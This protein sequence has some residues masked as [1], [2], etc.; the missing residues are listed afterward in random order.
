MRW[1]DSQIDHRRLGVS[2]SITG[3]S[4]A[5][6]AARSWIFRACRP[7]L[8]WSLALFGLGA[9]GLAGPEAP[10]MVRDF[11]PGIQAVRITNHAGDIFVETWNSRFIRV[12]A[13]S[14]AGASSGLEEIVLCQAGPDGVADVRTRQDLPAAQAVDLWLYVPAGVRLTARSR[15]GNVVILPEGDPSGT[16]PGDSPRLA[17]EMAGGEG[18]PA[19]S[20]DAPATSPR[21]A[22][23]SGDTAGA[24]P[25]GF[26]LKVDTRLVSL[27]VKVDNEAGASL[28][29]LC[30]EDFRVLDNGAEQSVVYFEPQAA[31]L[32]LL[33]LLDL[34]GSTKDKTNLIKRA[35]ARFVEMLN[36]ADR[37]AVAAFTSRYMQVSGFTENR[38][39]LRQR[40]DKIKNRGG[41][42]AFYEAMWYAQDE[43]ADTPGRRNIIV[44]MSDGVDNVLQFPD[45]YHSKWSFEE[46]LGRVSGADI[47]VFPVY[48]DTEYEQVVEE[49]NTSSITYRTARKQIASLAE[50]S[51]GTMFTVRRFEDLEGVYRLVASELRNLYTLSYYAPAKSGGGREWHEVKVEIKQ[52]GA[53]ARTRPGY[54]LH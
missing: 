53:R 23:A 30:L 35:A 17:E 26:R 28:A 27:N 20:P 24:G 38:L 33:L 15:D 12:V 11:V 31:P 32:N 22:P 19:G 1:S 5:A 3:R 8:A 46:M 6:G 48:L 21:P 40:I 7:W 14:R 54:Y 41:G 10:S 2:R 36:P 25:P 9:E 34:S 39:L 50:G 47:T 49:G 52:A 43:F 44:V 29:G 13:R 42:T 18:G 51:G 4:R 16:V 37:V 45:Q